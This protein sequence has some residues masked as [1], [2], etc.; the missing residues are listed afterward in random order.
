MKGHK[1]F[2]LLFETKIGTQ[3]THLET[4]QEETIWGARV[5][6]I[7]TGTYNTGT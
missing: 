1:D 5:K 2:W 6:I 4:D 3:L 7:Y